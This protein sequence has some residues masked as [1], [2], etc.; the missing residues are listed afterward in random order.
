VRLTNPGA[1]AVNDA[2]NDTDGLRAAPTGV[3]PPAVRMSKEGR[4][5]V[6]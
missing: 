2:V 4:S 1:I 3:D 5:H 6:V